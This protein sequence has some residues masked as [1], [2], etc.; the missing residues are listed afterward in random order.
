MKT[1]NPRNTFL[2]I[3]DINPLSLQPVIITTRH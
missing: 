2:L 3:V 1:L